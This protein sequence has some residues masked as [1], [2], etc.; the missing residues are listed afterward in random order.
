[1]CFNK[2]Q[3][4]IYF[5]NILVF[6]YFNNVQI[7]LYFNIQVSVYFAGHEVPKSPFMVTVTAAPGDASKVSL[8]GPGIQRTGNTANKTTYFDVATAGMCHLS[9]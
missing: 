6:V 8:T 1:M 2:V 4:L 5:K 9:I 7:S 3:V